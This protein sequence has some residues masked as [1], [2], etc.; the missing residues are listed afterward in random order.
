ML[1]RL[2]VGQ[3]H[4]DLLFLDVHVTLASFTYCVCV[5]GGQPAGLHLMRLQTFV[6]AG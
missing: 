6:E 1:S 2:D 5:G 4:V 3:A